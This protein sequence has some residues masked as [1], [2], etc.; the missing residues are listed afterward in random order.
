M[1]CWD[2]K[3][4]Y[5]SRRYL[6]WSVRTR[7][8]KMHLL[9]AILYN[10]GACVLW[11]LFFSVLPSCCWYEW[12][13]PVSAS[14]S[15]ASSSA[16]DSSCAVKRP[17]CVYVCLR[18]RVRA[19]VFACVRWIKWE[20]F[21]LAKK[22]FNS[23]IIHDGSHKCNDFFRSKTDGYNCRSHN[24]ILYLLNSACALIAT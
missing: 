16:S 22:I 17:S 8:T 20:M 1:C 10:S 18:V 2:T 12:G 6:G 7:M 4:K 9:V 14:F 3:G 13:E 21:G 19:C 15:V 11:R 5:T 23:N 24:E